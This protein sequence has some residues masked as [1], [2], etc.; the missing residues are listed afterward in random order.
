MGPSHSKSRVWPWYKL[1]DLVVVS[2]VL[3]RLDECDMRLRNTRR[4]P[5]HPILSPGEH[6]RPTTSQPSFNRSQSPLSA[7]ACQPP[8]NS[9]SNSR[10]ELFLSQTRKSRP[11][12][13]PEIV[14]ISLALILIIVILAILIAHCLAW[15]I[16]YKTEA[17][18]GE[19]RKGLLRG[20]DMRVCLCAR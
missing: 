13:I 18:L 16:V 12:S 4:S 19:V 5:H 8:N 14:C 6:S 15:F 1:S 9:H 20:G 11:F 10:P 2:E 17:R 3:T 7:F